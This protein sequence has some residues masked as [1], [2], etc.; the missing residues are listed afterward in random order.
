VPTTG[1]HHISRNR[2]PSHLL[3]LPRELRN[4][5]YHELWKTTPKICTHQWPYRI[6]I[7][8]DSKPKPDYERI[9]D[10]SG[11]GCQP[12][13]PTWLLTNKQILKEGLE[14]LYLMSIFYCEPWFTGSR[15]ASSGCLSVLLS[16]SNAKDVMLQVDSF[17]TSSFKQ[18]ADIINQ[19][20]KVKT[21]RINLATFRRSRTDYPTYLSFVQA[22]SLR[23]SKLEIIVTSKRQALNLNGKPDKKNKSHYTGRPLA[24][25][26]HPSRSAE[27]FRIAQAIFA[28]PIRVQEWF[29]VKHV[30]EEKDE[31]KWINEFGEWRFEVS[32]YRYAH[33]TEALRGDRSNTAKD[34]E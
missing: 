21:L 20:F 15:V 4:T 9:D 25:D 16:P 11:P 17:L 31:K 28:G 14:Q 8:Y 10:Q 30:E 7:S 26:L 34:A 6:Q 1:M 12:Y 5:V 3:N 32:K 23:L 18:L 29:C 2:L 33:G 19:S 13:L 24:T 22:F 27:V